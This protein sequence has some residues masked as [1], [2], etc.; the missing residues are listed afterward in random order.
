MRTCPLA[1]AFMMVICGC[2]P[3]SRTQVRFTTWSGIML[4][5][6]AARH[7]GPSGPGDRLDFDGDLDLDKLTIPFGVDADIWIGSNNLG[8]YVSSLSLSGKRTFGSNK[9]F[10][11]QIFIAGEPVRSNFDLTLIRLG[12]AAGL[13][14]TRGDHITFETNFEFINFDLDLRSSSAQVSFDGKVPAFLVGVVGSFHLTEKTGLRLTA[15]GLSLAGLFGFDSDFY[16]VQGKFQDYHVEF[17]WDP[18]PWL[19]IRTGLR[20]FAMEIK[21]ADGD[22]LKVSSIGPAVALEMRF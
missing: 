22:L 16:E 4:A 14:N 6:G 17:T 3:E 20:A 9:T 13:R 11:G 19:D 12:W 18:Y 5:D 8:I 7:P 2:N 21:N 1:I 10:G 15:R